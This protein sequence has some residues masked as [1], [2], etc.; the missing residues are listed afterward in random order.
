MMVGRAQSQPRV[1]QAHFA[2]LFESFVNLRLS[3]SLSDLLSK[4]RSKSFER[5][6]RIGIVLCQMKIHFSGIPR[7]CISNAT[8]LASCRS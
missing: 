6:F 8:K 4:K 3:F 1:N 5:K 7:C 2:C